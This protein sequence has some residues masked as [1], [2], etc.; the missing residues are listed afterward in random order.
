MTPQAPSPQATA[1]AQTTSN[2]TSG[3]ASQFLN[4]VDQTGPFGSIKYNQTGTQTY[5]DANGQTVKVP[6]FSSTTTLSPEQQALYDRQI[7]AGKNL[8]DLAVNQ[9]GRLNTVLGQE[10][11]PGNLPA[12][13]DGSVFSN[14]YSADRRRVED[15]IL[16]RSNEG[17]DRREAAL[18]S[19]LIN[20]GLTPGSEGWR[21]QMDQLGR[22]RNDATTQAIL[23]GGQEQSRMAGLDVQKLNTQTGLRG[24][25]LQEEFAFRNQPINE[26]AALLSGS[27]VTAPTFSQPYQQGVGAAPI[28]QYMQ[29]DYRNRLNSYNANMSGLFGLGSTLASGLFT[30]SDRRAKTN[31]ERIG[32]TRDGMGIYKYKYR[33]SPKTEIGLLAQEVADK[34]PEA[35]ARRPDG[36]LAVDYA[37][38]L[39]EAA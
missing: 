8:G 5:T 1:Q 9:S 13:A 23:T 21:E 37:A 32:K 34:R 2:V 18:E 31:I 15:A 4:N 39:S 36:L 7:A 10:F 3:V 16:T 24:N 35:V 6:K 11:D 25:A 33:G 17:F 20:Q 29:D 26:I 28:G 14:D 19:K 27:Q 38:A 12:R 30:L 22:D